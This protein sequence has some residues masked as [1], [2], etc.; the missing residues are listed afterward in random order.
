LLSEGGYEIDRSPQYSKSGPGVLQLGLDEAVV[1][2]LHQ[3]Q[4]TVAI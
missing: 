4:A 1:Q 3:L 2:S